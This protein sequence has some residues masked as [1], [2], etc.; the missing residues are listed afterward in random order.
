MSSAFDDTIDSLSATQDERTSRTIAPANTGMQ[1]RTRTRPRHGLYRYTID[2]SSDLKILKV[3]LTPVILQQ[4]GSGLETM[5][6]CLSL[7]RTFLGLIMRYLADLRNAAF[8]SVEMD[9][10]IEL[11]FKADPGSRR[12]GNGARSE[13]RGPRYGRD[14][15]SR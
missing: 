12:S 15:Q 1:S 4:R 5:P 3:L 10:A 9:L 6:L 2:G 11:L 8:S 14:I 7:Y 13:I